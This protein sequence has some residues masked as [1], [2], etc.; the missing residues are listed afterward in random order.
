M[1]KPD[2]GPAFGEFSEM[3]LRDFFA[4][5]ALNGIIS[6]ESLHASLVKAGSTKESP[7]IGQ[8]VEAAYIYAD[9]MLGERGK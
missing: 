5:A 2:G 8:V 6:C 4:A 9:A 7:S 1:S 3:T